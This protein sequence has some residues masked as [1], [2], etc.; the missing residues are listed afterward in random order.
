[1]ASK[2]L[3]WTRRAAGVFLVFFVFVATWPGIMP[4]NRIEPL[5]LGLPFIMAWYA[6]LLL[7][8]LVVLYLVD[9][10]ESREREE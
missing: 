7:L 3:R 6:G 10:V 5:I 8:T 2:S 9:R 4:F 1:M